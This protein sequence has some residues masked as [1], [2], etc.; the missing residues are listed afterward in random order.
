MIMIIL[1]HRNYEISRAILDYIM[2]DGY[3]YYLNI[4]VVNPM[5]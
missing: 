5:P 1:A 2:D 4:N 3:L